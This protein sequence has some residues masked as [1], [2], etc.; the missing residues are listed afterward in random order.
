VARQSHDLL[1]KTIHSN[2]LIYNACW[3]DPRLDRELLALDSNSQIVMLTSAGCNALD[4]LLDSPAAIHTVDVNPRQNALLQLKL[5]L[6][7]HGNFDYFAI[8]PTCPS[9]TRLCSHLLGQTV[10]LL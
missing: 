4:Y 7:R 9:P 5:T 2:T 6:L 1:F 8:P 10:A 3:E